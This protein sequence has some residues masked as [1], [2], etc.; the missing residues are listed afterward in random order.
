MEV[1]NI[2]KQT[3]FLSENE[4]KYCLVWNIG[5]KKN[6]IYF[7]WN[8]VPTHPCSMFHV[9]SIKTWCLKHGKKKFEKRVKTE[10][11]GSQQKEE[12]KKKKKGRRGNGD[13]GGSK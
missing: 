2:D 5:I 8:R 12:E 7:T 13:A 11:R 3:I 9:L 4:S 1:K 6:S 10:V